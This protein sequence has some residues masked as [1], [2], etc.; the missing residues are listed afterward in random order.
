MSKSLTNDESRPTRNVEAILDA[1]NRR[2][3]SLL[4]ALKMPTVGVNQAAPTSMYDGQDNSI[5][6]RPADVNDGYVLGEELGHCIRHQWRAKGA[7]DPHQLE[8]L[9]PGSVAA[10]SEFFGFIG[11]HVA[12]EACSVTDAKELF[13]EESVWSGKSFEETVRFVRRQREVRENLLRERDELSHDASRMLTHVEGLLAHLPISKM[14]ALDR[15]KGMLEAA[16]QS[17]RLRES[18]NRIV[19]RRS[20]P[21][22]NVEFLNGLV[23]VMDGLMNDAQLAMANQ[24]VEKSLETQKVFLKEIITELRWTRILHEDRMRR[25][26]HSAGYSSAAWALE[27]EPS[28]TDLFAN[29]VAIPDERVFVQRIVCNES[30]VLKG[31]PRRLWERGVLWTFGLL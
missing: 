30:G 8:A 17:V 20:L 27:Q 4:S 29:L 18:D 22:R 16:Q 2:A 31:L 28:A 10:V 13:A 11:R 7:G 21:H 14:D 6:L 3:P 15:F 12:E 23:Q 9:F 24:L 1:M 19:Y 26:G 5:T 25:D